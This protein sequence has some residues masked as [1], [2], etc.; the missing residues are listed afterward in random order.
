[1]SSCISNIMSAPVRVR[2]STQHHDLRQ[3]FQDAT[4]HRIH[5]FRYLR[6]TRDAVRVCEPADCRAYSTGIEVQDVDC[7][8]SGQQIHASAS[9]APSHSSRPRQ[10]NEPP[11]A[12]AHLDGSQCG[13]GFAVRKVVLRRKHNRWREGVRPATLQDLPQARAVGVDLRRIAVTAPG[14]D[15]MAFAGLK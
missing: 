9:N 4:I 3:A 5:V 2:I 10:L 14:D 6:G 12:R 7:A 15:C 11:L 1:M 13:R 8:A